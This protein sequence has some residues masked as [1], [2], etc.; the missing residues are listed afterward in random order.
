MP[1]SESQSPDRARG[2]AASAAPWTRHQG[3]RHRRGGLLQGNKLP[4]LSARKHKTGRNRCGSAL[5]LFAALNAH[6]V[7]S[8]L[9]SMR[10]A[11]MVGRIYRGR[12][13]QRT[14]MP[15]CLPSGLLSDV[16]VSDVSVHGPGL[17]SWVVLDLLHP[18]PDRL[19]RD[20]GVHPH[21]PAPCEHEGH[22]QLSPLL[23]ARVTPLRPPPSP[24]QDKGLSPPHDC[25]AV[26]SRVLLQHDEQLVD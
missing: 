19:V 23:C 11:A 18:P 9:L 13:S 2:G 4:E 8:S 14:D 3:G 22:Q 6:V 17:V 10:E 24:D 16:R 25:R 1:P 26:E 7:P 21:V 5:A 15:R 12:A 20:D